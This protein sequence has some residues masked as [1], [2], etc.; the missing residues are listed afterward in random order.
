MGVA[1]GAPAASA[2]HRDAGWSS[3]EALV[4]MIIAALVASMA[5]PVTA[6]AIDSGRARHAAGFVAS[7]LRLARQE[8][9]Y[10]T[11]SVG[12]V[13][14]LA[15]SRWTF[16]ICVDGD[17]DGIRRTDVAS[18]KDPCSEGPYDLQDM[19]PG[20][21]IEVDP[22]LSGP[23]GSA[24][25]PNPVRFGSSQIASFSPAGSCTAGTLYVRSQKGVQ[26]AVRVGNVSGRTRILR[27]DTGTSKWI[28]G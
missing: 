25:S 27:Y 21:L 17:K 12:V 7:R 9:V 15:G 24:P 26:Y 18:G 20:V 1:G 13:F 10:K 5:V 23:E 8:A 3:I 2:E 11:R 22:A 6:N 4:V 28:A 19:F 16:R 14:D